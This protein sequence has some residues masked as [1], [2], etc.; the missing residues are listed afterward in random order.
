MAQSCRQLPAFNKRNP[1]RLLDSF[2]PFTQPL[3]LKEARS[4]PHF[5]WMSIAN[6][7]QFCETFW[8][9]ADVYCEAV[10]A[11]RK[12]YDA[13]SVIAGLRLT[14]QAVPTLND[15]MG[16]VRDTPGC[17]H[18]DRVYAHGSGARRAAMS[19]VSSAFFI[20]LK[21]LEEITLLLNR[22]SRARCIEGYA[23][24]SALAKTSR[25]RRRA[26]STAQHRGIPWSAVTKRPL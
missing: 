15:T 1:T 26:H 25:G 5:I 10:V 2:P 21:E 20:P 7:T 19:G 23:D 6:A 16:D 22:E 13:R 12:A 11:K 24:F 3:Y 4:R 18:D 9:A 17:S 14:R 8:T